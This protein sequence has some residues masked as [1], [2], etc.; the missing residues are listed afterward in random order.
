MVG[1]AAV[2]CQCCQFPIP[3]NLAIMRPPRTSERGIIVSK[4]FKM[5]ASL[6]SIAAISMSAYALNDS[7]RAEIEERIKPHGE[8]CLVGDDSCGGAAVA[9]SAGPRSGE[10]VYNA[11]C[12]ACHATG[13]GGAPLLGDTA[14]WAD[15]IAKGMDVLYDSGINGL[16]GTG[17]I[18]KG[19]C[20]N[21]SDEEVNA[22]VDFMVAG[23][24]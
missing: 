2:N 11:A 22:A 3:P 5:L 10:D 23:S 9:T 4:T 15:R 18:A 8:V 19:G 6:L 20:M 16:A 13:A 7:Q 17:M 21:C 12:M 14:A 24:K 1:R